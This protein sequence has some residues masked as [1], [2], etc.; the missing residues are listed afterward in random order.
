MSV[1]ENFKELA[2]L[3]ANNKIP[4][5]KYISLR[6]GLTVTIAQVEGP[7]VNG[8][9]CLAT[10]AHDDDGLPHT[11]EHLIFLGSEK[12]PFKGVLDLLANRCLSSGTNAWTDTDHTCYTMTTAGSEGFLNLF[13]I[14]LDHI[15]YPT[16]T[17]SGY[18]TEVHHVNGEGEDAGV[19]YCEMQGRE[20]SGES[21]V[22]LA[23]LRAIYPGK[24]GYKS[25]TGGIMKNLRESTS[26]EKVINYHK[27][28]YRPEN[29]GVV[30]TGQV[31]IEEV[32]K[33]CESFEEKI[34]SKG[35]RDPFLRPWSGEVPKLEVGKE[36]LVPY[37]ADDEDNGMVYIA[38]R[39][40]SAVTNLYRMFATMILM[41]YLT[42]TSVS[43]LQA[44]F[45]EI[46]SPYASTVG[47]N[48]IENKESAVYLMFE[49]VP[50]DKID[51]VEPEL[52]KVLEELV[53]GIIPWDFQRLKTVINRRILEQMSQLEN[54]P[55]DAVAFMAIGDMLY[56][57]TQEDLNIRLN[58]G[59]EFR[60]MHEEPESFWINIIGD[61]LIGSPKIVVKGVPSVELQ[62][63]MRTEEEV[64]IKDQRESLGE[65]GLLKKQSELDRAMELNEVEAPNE[66][67]QSVPIPS[68][69]SV[70]FHPVKSFTTES[71]IQMENFDLKKMPIYFQFDQI[72]SNFV[73]LFTVLDTTDIPQNLKPYL[74]LVTELL[75]ESPLLDG[76]NEIPYEKVVAQLSEDCLESSFSLGVAGHRFLPGSFAQ[77]AVL[78][79]QA[80]P[81][82]YEVAV[83]WITKLLFH[84]KFTAERAKVLATKMEN[85]V[86]ELKR[87]GS[88][89]VSIM[90]NAVLF[91]EKSNHQVSNMIKQQVF[92]KDLQKRLETNP[93][94]VIKD[95]EEVR[96]HLTKP[97]NMLVHMATDISI[98]ENPMSPWKSFLPPHIPKKVVSPSCSPEHLM[99]LSP[100]AHFLVG[101]GSCESSFLSRTTPCITD[102][103]SP[104]LPALML[105]IQ[106]LTQLEGP[107]WRQIRG[108]GLAYGYSVFPNTNKGQLYMSLYKAT[109]PLKAFEEAKR[110]VMSHVKN[111][112]SWDETLFESAKSS[113]IFELIEREK[114]ISEA[115]QESIISSFKG[116]DR[117]Y[118]RQFLELID[119]V[120][121]EELVNVG[122]KYLAPL[123]EENTRTTI[124]CSPAKLGEIKDGFGGIGVALKVLDSVD[125]IIAS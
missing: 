23:M 98:L 2:S 4:V 16:L 90:M 85:S 113:L 39:G 55:H 33:T 95:L 88:K 9:F 47:Y 65:E 53:K 109:H 50:K 18:L 111:K 124:V 73:Y 15:L 35:D 97:S 86:S 25:E 60:K 19:V 52:E 57:N 64:R 61:M 120:N 29:L 66:V 72:G 17:P 22:H 49:N 123:F 58:S 46:D 68:A 102:P 110:I 92:L 7:V 87:K 101:L 122:L 108:A 70:K 125:Q 69:T 115:V 3:K 30:I 10:E 27:E 106:Y 81:E 26:N 6:T 20:N 89:V 96:F 105:A 1:F 107:M 77:S 114:S 91:S 8:Y 28:F 71:E 13:P 118:N 82:K 32:L 38:W 93:N 79:L 37:P 121:R 31:D 83:H 67:L 45:V 62:K 12:F 51:E 40:P 44:R 112:D 76:S 78:F 24:C 104:D 14:Y 119:K 54:S 74:P 36:I 103:K 59:A 94:E 48:F 63:S 117:K 116:V 99:T 5:T 84:S 43:P 75:L 42:E 80:E 21:L 100:P 41:E 34:V 56:G 11:L